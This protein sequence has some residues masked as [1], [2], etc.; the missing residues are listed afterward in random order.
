MK[1]MRITLCFLLIAL[2]AAA[3]LGDCNTFW[4]WL[5]EPENFYSPRWEAGLEH[6]LIWCREMGR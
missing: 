6:H 2:T 1:K 3:Q 5:D 4:K